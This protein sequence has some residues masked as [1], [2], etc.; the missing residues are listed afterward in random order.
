LPICSV[1]LVFHCLH[2][3]IGCGALIFSTGFILRPAPVLVCRFL[4]PVLLDLIFCREQFALVSAC[5]LG[6][7]VF[8]LWL[9]FGPATETSL[10]GP[11][12]GEA[13]C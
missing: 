8:G 11:R 2:S 9:V 1:A 5:V 13:S 7:R 3:I 4:T 12:V 6:H 10:S